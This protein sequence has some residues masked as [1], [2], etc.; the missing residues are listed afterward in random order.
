MQACR[1]HCEQVHFTNTHA[2]PLNTAIP[3]QERN[4]VLLTANG[5]DLV[6]RVNFWEPKTKPFKGENKRVPWLGQ[7]HGWYKH[8]NNLILEV[9]KYCL[10]M[11]G[12]D[13]FFILS[14]NCIAFIFQKKCQAYVCKMCLF[15]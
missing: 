6:V 1:T 14:T 8:I 12:K 15:F 2:R 7:L 4:V 9:H 5:M 3:N 13:S 10:A 11:K